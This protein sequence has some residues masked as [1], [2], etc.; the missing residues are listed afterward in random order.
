MRAK[1]AMV[2]VAGSN[3]VPSVRKNAYMRLGLTFMKLFSSVAVDV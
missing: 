3:V 1:F 2:S